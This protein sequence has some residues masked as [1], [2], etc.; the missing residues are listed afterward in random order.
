MVIDQDPHEDIFA[1]VPQM[2]GRIDPILR[3]LDQLLD[4]DSLYQAVRADFGLRHGRTLSLG[5][6]STPV[7]ALLRML[8]LKHLHGWSFQETE[9][10]VDQNVILRWFCRL[11]WQE[12]PDGTTLIRLPAHAAARDPA[13][14]GGAHR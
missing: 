8:L 6:P 7:E 9:D 1:R 4:D 11:S 2:A 13:S 12:T 5:R 10:Q 3:Q 14:V